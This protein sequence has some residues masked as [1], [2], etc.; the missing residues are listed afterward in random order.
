MVSSC[1]INHFGINPVSGGSPPNESKARVAVAVRMGVL[2]QLV[3]NVLIF[4]ALINLNVRKVA[5]VIMIYRHNVR[6][7]SC[8][9][10]C[11]IM[12]IHPRWAIDE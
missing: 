5:I 2:A 9:F 4:V 3:A 10:S 8:G 11:T 12:I 7:V 6:M 1:R